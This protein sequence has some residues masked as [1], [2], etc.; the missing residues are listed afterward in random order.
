MGFFDQGINWSK[1]SGRLKQRLEQMNQE[2]RE[3][4]A[5]QMM[6]TLEGSQRGGLYN[7][8]SFQS[9]ALQNDLRKRRIAA[10]RLFGSAQALSVLSG[11]AD[12]KYTNTPAD[13]DEAEAGTAN[14]AERRT[15]GELRKKALLKRAYEEEEQRG[16]WK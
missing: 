15:R 11:K 9:G 5:E 13:V 3:E 14:V 16:F 4:E 2:A 8:G 12:V 7:S 10:N 1:P 6:S